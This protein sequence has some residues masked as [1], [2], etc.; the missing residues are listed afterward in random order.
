MKSYKAVIFDLDGTLLDTLEDIANAMNC[1]LESTGFPTHTFDSYRYF[2]GDG[3]KNLVSRTLPADKRNTENI[4]N[5]LEEFRK[6]YSLNWNVKTKPYEGIPEMLDI[7]TERDIKMSVLSNKPHDFTK[8]CVTKLLPKW[9]FHKVLGQRDSVPPKPDPAGAIE[10]SE[11]LMIPP[12]EFLYIG[13]TAID[14]KTAIAAGMFPVGVL[15]GFRPM[16]ELKENGA[17][18]LINH[19]LEIPGLL[20]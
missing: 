14:L 18:A 17:R 9:K 4:S 6:T 8:L 5:C 13:D 11:Y 7:L 3:V 20:I 2:V 16:E 15:W 1:V 10:I 12:S 19:P